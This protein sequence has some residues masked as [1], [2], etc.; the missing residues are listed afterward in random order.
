MPFLALRSIVSNGPMKDRHKPRPS[1]IAIYLVGVAD[2]IFDQ[3]ERLAKDCALKPIDNEAVDL[4]P[5]ASR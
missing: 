4:A 1:G 2:T 5:R 3:A